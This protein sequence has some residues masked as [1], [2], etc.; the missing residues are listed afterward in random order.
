M[1]IADPSRWE[2]V[3][4]KL[5]TNTLAGGFYRRF[6]DDMGLRGDE[7]VMDFGSGTGAAAVRLAPILRKGGGRLTCV[8]VSGTWIAELRKVLRRYPEVEYLEGRLWELDLPDE[9]FDVVVA[10][11]VL[12]DIPS[13]G[14]SGGDD[15]CAREVRGERERAVCELARVL[16]MG[17]RFFVRD[18]SS[19]R[20]GFT[21]GQLAALLRGA[22]LEEVRSWSGRLYLVEPWVAAEYRKPRPGPPSGPRPGR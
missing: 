11:F 2:V 19:E 1:S 13:G 6:V 20:H 4:H 17:G 21:P 15:G 22:G 18:P 8:D 3:T 7:R 10:H 9:S 12:H 14:S 16:R 5:F